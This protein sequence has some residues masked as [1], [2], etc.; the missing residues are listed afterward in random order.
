MLYSNLL[1]GIDFLK[2]KSYIVYLKKYNMKKSILSLLFLFLS[3]STFCQ[4]DLNDENVQSKIIINNDRL[5]VLEFY[6][7]WSGP[8]QRMK[9]TIKALANEYKNIDFY[10]MDVDRYTL[11]DKLQIKAMP[12]YLFIKNSKNL[13]Q[14]E[15]VMSKDKFIKLINKHLASK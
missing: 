10:K 8:C 4:T 12:T 5:I 6:A 2:L 9:K 3:L 14:I 15:G 13:E 1:Q 7:S 11:D